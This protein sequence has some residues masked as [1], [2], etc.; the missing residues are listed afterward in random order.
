MLKILSK[1]ASVL[2][3]ALTLSVA[4]AAELYFPGLETEWETVDPADLGWDAD[5]LAQALDV[6]GERQSS[7]VLILHNGRIMAERYWQDPDSSRRYQNALQGFDAQGRAIEDVASAQKNITSVLTGMAQA[8]GYLQLDDT[9]SSHLGAGWS[10]ASAE[11]EAEITI[12]HLLT[13]TSGLANDLSFETVPESKWL[14]N[15]PAY[16][17][18]MRIVSAATGKERNALTEAWIT[19]PLGMTQSSWTPRPWASADIGVGFSTTAR[20]LARFG[21][22][23][24][25]NG[26]WAGEA[27]F[28]DTD[29]IREMLSPSQ[30]LNP[31]YGYLWWLNGQEFT[32][33][34]TP[35][36]P[37][38][39]GQL[40]SSAPADL[41]AMQGALDRKLYL[42]PSLNLIVT[43][44]GSAGNAD[45][46][47]FNNAFWEALMKA[48]PQ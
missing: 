11:Q 37:R 34:T 3:L 29:Y 42:V 31:A 33:G 40:I 24:Q 25:A 44:L 14:Y 10:K 47:N 20:D 17:F 26:T 16:H 21:L 12:R 39:N 8:R 38:R 48:R 35:S 6:A 32:V 36:A 22:M 5:L 43:R 45:G 18:L 2:L 4:S 28:E 7:G 30:N 9:V 15:T 41:V 27:V 19:G 46:K 1:S 13:M 23:I